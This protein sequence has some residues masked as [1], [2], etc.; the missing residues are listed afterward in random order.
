[1]KKSNKLIISNAEPVVMGPHDF[2][3]GDYVYAPCDYSEDGDDSRKGDNRLSKI[4]GIEKQHTDVLFEDLNRF[5]ANIEYND[6]C[7]VPI[8]EDW[9]KDNPQVFTPSDNINQSDGSNLRFSYQY[10]FS[11][12][13]FG[14]DFYAVAYEINYEDEEEYIR[15]RQAGL[16]FLASIKESQGKATILQFVR[17]APGTSDRAVGVMQVVAIHELQ[18]FLRLC[19]C[20]ELN[21]P[22]DLLEW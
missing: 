19:G 20:G 18:H 1:M 14:C 22:K 4:F 15:L 7:I 17:Y 8:T 12:T 13:R 9:F 21:A 5:N 6:I 2:Q 11:A 3:F 10:K 16:G